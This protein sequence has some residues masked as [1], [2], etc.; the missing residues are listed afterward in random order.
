MFLVNNYSWHLHNIKHKAQIDDDSDS[1]EEIQKDPRAM[2]LDT[3]GEVCIWWLDFS[4]VMF[5]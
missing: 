1:E 2:I 3:D 4:V 5:L